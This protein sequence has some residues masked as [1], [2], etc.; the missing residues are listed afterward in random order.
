MTRTTTARILTLC[1]ALACILPA[2]AKVDVDHD[3]SVDFSVF[4][5]YA[6]ITGTHAASP[7]YHKRI[8]TAIDEAM[9]DRGMQL[10]EGEADI[11]LLYHASLTSEQVVNVD[12]YG[13]W[14]RGWAGAG[15]TTVDVYDI[16]VGTL[17]VDMLVGADQDLAWRGIGDDSFTN[18]AEKNEKKINKI[19]GKMFRLF[20]PE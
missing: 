7:L 14:G 5:T 16:Q 2:A 18:K 12:S 19:V 3:S 20:P 15:T 11:Y 6:W 9:A 4:K 10:V 1:L 8:V 17:I 13:Y